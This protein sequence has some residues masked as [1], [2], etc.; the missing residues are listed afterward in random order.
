MKTRKPAR[1]E[2]CSL[3]ADQWEKIVDHAE[4]IFDSIYTNTIYDDYQEVLNFIDNLECWSMISPN[5]RDTLRAYAFDLKQEALGL[6]H[7]H[8][9]MILKLT[10]G[11]G[12]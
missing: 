8:E 12:E 9:E 4:Y 11:I 1:P 5:D 7:H 10:G 3:N 2:W 6:W